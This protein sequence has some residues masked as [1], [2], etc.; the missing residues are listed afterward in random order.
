LMESPFILKEFELPYQSGDFASLHS[1]K[2]KAYNDCIVKIVSFNQERLRFA[3][4]LRNGKQILVKACNLATWM[5]FG[6]YEELKLLF[7]RLQDETNTSV[8]KIERVWNKMQNVCGDHEI[9]ARALKSVIGRL[10]Y[11]TTDS[12]VIAKFIGIAKSFAVDVKDPGL[13][14]DLTLRIAYCYQ[15][16]GEPEQAQKILFSLLSRHQGRLLEILALINDAKIHLQHQQKVKFLIKHGLYVYIQHCVHDFVK[17]ILEIFSMNPK[18]ANDAREMIILLKEEPEGP[19]AN[20]PSTQQNLYEIKLAIDA[21]LASIEERYE[22]AIEKLTIY[23]QLTTVQF[24]RSSIACFPILQ[25]LFEC[26]RKFGDKK[27]AKQILKRMK[28]INKNHSNICHLEKKLARMKES[29]KR[30]KTKVKATRCRC[31]NPYCHKVEQKACEF[32]LC[33]RCESVKYCS[34]RC[35]VKHWKSGHRENCEK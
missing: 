10:S 34:R 24:G 13:K 1:L 5:H 31:S 33:E 22:D 12:S 18:F 17:T 30:S 3:V 28:R 16:I 20:D 25:D 8:K 15:I 35:Q 2:N 32:S 4:T 9:L 19:M 21:F 14:V 26:Y 7:D 11:C 23:I 27:R 29:G 6:P